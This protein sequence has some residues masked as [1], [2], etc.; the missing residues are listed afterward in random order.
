V[1]PLPTHRAFEDRPDRY[2]ALIDWDRRLANETPFYRRL[3]EQ[4]GVDRVLDAAC[5]TGR[6]AAMFHSWG[7]QVEGADVSPA[8]IACCRKSFG[9]SDTLRWVERSF[10]QPVD[11]PQPFDAV[12]CVGNSLA[13][14]GDDQIVDRA[15]QMML[16]A[17][18]PGGV[19]VVQI[20]NV[21]RLPEG[22]TIWQKCRRVTRAGEDRILLKSIHRVEARA[23]VDLVE[24]TLTDNDVSSHIDSAVF[25]GIQADRLVAAAEA[26]GGVEVQLLGDL[27]GQI[28]DSTES[29]DLILLCR[30]Q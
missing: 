29:Q 12:V 16:A 14:A 15:M 2:D 27:K 10:D 20:L 18:R 4:V 1:D 7:L 21:W 3:F 8:M 17:L 6:H 25:E 11:S 9:E 23:Y 24:L 22:D 28:Y 5:G 13:L 26:G 19:C 30:R